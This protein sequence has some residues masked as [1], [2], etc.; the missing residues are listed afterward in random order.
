[1]CCSHFALDVLLSFCIGRVA[2]ILHWTCGSHLPHVWCK[3][4]KR[5]RIGCVAIILHWTRCSHS[6][7][8]ALLSFCIG[9][10][11]LICPTSNANERNKH[12]LDVLFSFCIGRVAFIL[13][14]TCGSHLYWTCGSHLQWTCGPHGLHFGPGQEVYFNLGQGLY[15]DLGQGLYFDLGHELYFGSGCTALR[16]HGPHG[17]WLIALWPRWHVPP[18]PI[19]L[20]N[21]SS[22]LIY[23]DTHV[24]IW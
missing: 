6:A 4:E 21:I 3:W 23:S 16:A 24:L 5:T 1:M 15:F 2:L 8:D 14:Y 22:D 19:Y 10:V 17:L 9:R 12:A 20:H 13:H 11:V 18:V 7:L